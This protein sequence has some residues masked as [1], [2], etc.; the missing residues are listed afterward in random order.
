MNKELLE[1]TK[2]RVLISYL[3]PCRVVSVRARAPTPVT[4]SESDG[5]RWF[6]VCSCHSSGCCVSQSS[7]VSCR[8]PWLRVGASMLS[9]VLR[10]ALQCRRGIQR[11]LWLWGY[12]ILARALRVM[13]I[14]CVP[15][16]ALA[17]SC[18]SEREAG[19]WFRIVRSRLIH[20]RWLARAA[21]FFAYK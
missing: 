3:F 1:W 17:L 13:P 5:A 10:V 11:V 12:F 15:S 16:P 8:A 9:L 19:R 18:S 7:A 14:R 4:P 6:L 20:A 2:F 21:L